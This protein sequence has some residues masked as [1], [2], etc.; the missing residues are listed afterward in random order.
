M[1]IAQRVQLLNDRFSVMQE[2][3]DILRV[4]VQVG[5]SC[6]RASDRCERVH[7]QVGNRCRGVGVRAVRGCSCRWAA[8]GEGGRG[9]RA[10]WFLVRDSGKGWVGGHGMHAC[11]H[12]P[13]RC[14]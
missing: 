6:G 4:H 10:G 3:L 5:K 2:L 12:R 8:A 7:V 11:M 13:G 1:E 9:R 14:D